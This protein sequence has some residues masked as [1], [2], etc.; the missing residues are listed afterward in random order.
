MLF[1][2]NLLFLKSQFRREGVPKLF[3]D[4]IKFEHEI[5]FF[6]ISK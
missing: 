5:P 4:V 2:Y 3:F 6:G 1:Y